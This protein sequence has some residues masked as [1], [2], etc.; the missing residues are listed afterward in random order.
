[1][2]TIRARGFSVATIQRVL[3]GKVKRRISANRPVIAPQGAANHDETTEGPWAAR[4]AAGVRAF[5]EWLPMREA[6]Y[7]RYELGDLATLFR[8]DTRLV[9]RSQ[10][11][12]PADWIEGKDDFE[13]AAVAFRDGA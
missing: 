9:G 10:Q 7:T 2:G 4:M 1:M 8:L 13:A 11:L 3:S 12:D 5:Q 6:P